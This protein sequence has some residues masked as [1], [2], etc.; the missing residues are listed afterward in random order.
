VI[1]WI[2]EKR[3]RKPNLFWHVRV[4]HFAGSVPR[5]GVETIKVEAWSSGSAQAVVAERLREEFA[6]CMITRVEGP[7]E[8]TP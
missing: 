3:R 5:D 7:Y 4:V 8:R 1:T 6:D 2:Q